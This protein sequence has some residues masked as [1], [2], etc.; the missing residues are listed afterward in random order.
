M[1]FREDVFVVKHGTTKRISIPPLLVG[2]VIGKG[3]ETIKSIRAKSGARVSVE[4]GQVVLCGEVNKIKTA[5]KIVLEIIGGAST[6]HKSIRIGN[7]Q[8]GILIGP[9]GVNIKEIQERSGAI[10]K[11]VSDDKGHHDA[12]VDITG[13]DEQIVYAEKLIKQKISRVAAVTEMSI[14]DGKIKLKQLDPK[15]KKQDLLDLYPDAY[16]KPKI[17]LRVEKGSVGLFATLAFTNKADVQIWMNQYKGMMLLNRRIVL[18][19]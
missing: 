9:K 6:T 19:K 1:D 10:V 7:S 14:C 2:K 4:D 17:V 11:I 16:A 13:S 18:V 5:E 8:V 12:K 15:V 3:G